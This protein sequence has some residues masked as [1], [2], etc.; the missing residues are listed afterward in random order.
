M[1]WRTEPLVRLKARHRRVARKASCGLCRYCHREAW[2]YA[3][4]ELHRRLHR[5]Q[6]RRRRAVTRE[7]SHQAPA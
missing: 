5:L 3:R 1:S 2:P 7:R 4:C 6:E